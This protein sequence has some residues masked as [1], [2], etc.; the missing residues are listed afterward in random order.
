MSEHVVS[1]EDDLATVRAYVFDALE[2]TAAGMA[3]S[4]LA[5][6]ALA[7]IESELL[8]RKDKP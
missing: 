5:F 4:R 1:V 6:A 2:A 8:N 3:E 7:R